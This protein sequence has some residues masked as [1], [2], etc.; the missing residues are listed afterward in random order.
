MEISDQLL[1]DAKIF[2]LV[3]YMVTFLTNK[4]SK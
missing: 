1:H 3:A 4:Q 2:N